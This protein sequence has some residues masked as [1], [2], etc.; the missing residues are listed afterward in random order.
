MD[1]ES[2]RNAVQMIVDL[3]LEGDVTRRLSAA[4][5]ERTSDRRGHRNGT[6]P[7]AMS[8]RPGRIKL[9]VFKVRDGGFRAAGV[10]CKE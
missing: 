1:K 6:K 5:Y 7:R 3:V 10:N 8:M 2:L 4:R 9:P